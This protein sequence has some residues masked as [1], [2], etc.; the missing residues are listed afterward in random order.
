M[1]NTKQCVKR[2]RQDKQRQ[3]RN[4]YVRRTIR[5]LAKKMKSDIPVEEKE[6]MISTIFSQLDRAAKKGV[7]HRRTASRRKS[8]ISSY[9]NKIKMETS[10]A[11]KS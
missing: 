11:A 4:N 2:L 3:A 10:A 9:L 5:T 8:R 7:I 6:K 1:P